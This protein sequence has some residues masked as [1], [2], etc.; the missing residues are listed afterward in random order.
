M[1]SSANRFA[2]NALASMTE[3]AIRALRSRHEQC[4]PPQF[5]AWRRIVHPWLIPLAIVI[6]PDQLNWR[7]PLTALWGLIQKIN[8][9][10]GVDRPA[11]TLTLSVPVG[12]RIA[13]SD[14]RT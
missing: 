13:T 14:S 1:V 7:R 12:Q 11:P 9:S 10:G 5:S 4:R 3:P 8:L 6:P 2:P